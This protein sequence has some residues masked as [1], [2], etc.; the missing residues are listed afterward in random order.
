MTG[1]TSVEERVE[2]ALGVEH[3]QFERRGAADGEHVF[4]GI[5]VHGGRH[6]LGETGFVDES[7][8]GGEREAE[9]GVVPTEHG[10][11]VDRGGVLEAA[12][13]DEFRVTRPDRRG[14]VEMI[15]P[16]PPTMWLTSPASG[17]VGRIAMSGGR[18]VAITTR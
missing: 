15:V 5:V 16:L 12:H 17:R 18:P 7:V 4:D 10:D 9:P 1:G 6:Q 14:N 2:G 13:V 8:V 11:H 3:E